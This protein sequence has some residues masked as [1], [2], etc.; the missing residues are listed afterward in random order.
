MAKT[1]TKK[2]N[3]SKKKTKEINKEILGII[4]TS[5]GILS[6]VSMFNNST[7]SIGI[8]I[9]IVFE[10]LAGIGGHILPYIIILIG[11]M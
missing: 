3:K 8:L 1:K 4:I 5:F 11:V 6:L 2:K 10:S 9:R 7:G